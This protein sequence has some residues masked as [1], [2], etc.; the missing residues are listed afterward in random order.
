MSYY[1]QQRLA[2]DRV[3]IREGFLKFTIIACVMHNSLNSLTGV[4][5]CKECTFSFGGSEMTGSYSVESGF[6]RKM[7]AIKPNHNI[8]NNCT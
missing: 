7:I 1:L 3:K 8:G 2:A 5:V 4:A 6:S